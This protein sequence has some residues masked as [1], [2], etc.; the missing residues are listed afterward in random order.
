M[1]SKVLRSLVIILF[2]SVLVAGVAAGQEQPNVPNTKDEGTSLKD[3]KK[4]K[5]AA[6]EA[7]KELTPEERK[8]RLS[9]FK[10]EVSKTYQN[11]LNQDVTYIISNEEEQAFK[12][13]ATDEER[14]QFIEQFW[15]RRDPTP[16]TQENEFREEH[17]RR[18]QYA[19]EHYA[20]GI[21]GWRTD[22]GRIYIVWGAPDEVESHPS[23]GS[24]QRDAKEGG[25]QTSTFPFERWRYRYLEGIGNE[26]IIEFV[27]SCQ[28]N[29]YHIS[30]DPNEKDALLHTPGGGPTTLE[31]MGRG[32]R[33]SRMMG[34]PGGQDAFNSGNQGRQFDAIER[35]AKLTSPPPVK[36]KDLEEKVNTKIR[37]KLM[38]FDLRVDFIKVTSDTALVPITIQMKVKDMTFL[39]KEGIQRA[40]VN[41]FGRITTLTGRVAATF[42][43]T[44]GVDEPNELLE[45]ALQTSQLYWK[46]LPL[47]SG[48]YK[49]DVAVK[50]V[51][52]DRVGTYTR[53]IR[54]PEYDDE[55][56]T[57]S[58]LILADLLER[59]PAK[60]VGAGNFIIGDLKVR[61]RVD[62]SDGKPA[63]FHR[64]QKLNIFLQVYNLQQDQQIHK[65]RGSI[66]YDIV[67]I[68]TN[69][70][71]LH[72]DESSAVY[73]NTGDQITIQKSMPL[74]GLE[75]GLYNLKITVNDDVTKQTIS[76]SAR[77]QVE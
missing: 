40:S 33:G 55:K 7:P 34:T 51:N 23:G 16:D 77:F 30:L 29:D 14:D 36:F 44:V 75:P 76:P 73:G 13:L 63:S 17:Y 49:I 60:T 3:L 69:K 64:D 25:G 53:S 66:S 2:S 26:I 61:P 48:M 59:V 19:N 31:E 12:L 67:N 32:N 54:V 56:L 57:S 74:A 35:Y 52:G 50:D 72:V 41:I 37:Y 45:K 21:P 47:K 1:R 10:K 65:T 18:I 24:Y 20:A 15:L 43:D 62:P 5:K 42:E 4:T 58:S 27:D 22:R 71:V 28:C 6:P 46:A 8:S 70:S 11:W 9:S 38:P 68:Q 39:Q